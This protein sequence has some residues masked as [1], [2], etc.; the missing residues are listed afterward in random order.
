VAFKAEEL[1]GKVFPEPEGEA[2]AM[3]P[4]DTLTNKGKPCNN[5]RPPCPQGSHPPG[6]GCPQD[7]HRPPGQA[8]GGDAGA[9]ALLQAQLRDRLARGPAA[10]GP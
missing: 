8:R 6:P 3:C 1:A 10:A 5:T 7:T 9:L 2:W 4:Q